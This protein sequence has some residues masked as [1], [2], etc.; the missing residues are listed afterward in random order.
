MP[1]GGVRGGNAPAA[2]SVH[3]RRAKALASR[4]TCVPARAEERGLWRAAGLP[5]IPAVRRPRTFSHKRERSSD[6]F[7]PFPTRAR[8]A[9]SGGER[10]AQAVPVA[11][12]QEAPIGPA[13]QL[14]DE[15][16]IRQRERRLDGRA[17][18][19]GEADRRDILGRCPQR[20]HR[21]RAPARPAVGDVRLPQRSWNSYLGSA[22]ASDRGEGSA[23]PAKAPATRSAMTAASSGS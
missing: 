2:P 15:R 16:R 18:C 20:A 19:G 22:E 10:F 4:Q 3:L 21:S 1:G 8:A 7:S 12:P 9:T 23:A 13:H 5:H 11:G 14:A 17:G 6:T